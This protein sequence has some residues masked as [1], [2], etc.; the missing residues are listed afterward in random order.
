MYMLMY[1]RMYLVYSDDTTN[2]NIIP[3]LLSSLNP[4]D[5]HE[6]PKTESSCQVST[7]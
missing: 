7:T 2:K 1:L 5:K 6:K 4:N 3:V